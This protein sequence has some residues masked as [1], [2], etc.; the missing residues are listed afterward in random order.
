MKKIILLVFISLL[1][2]GCKEKVFE[3]KNQ[4]FVKL[5]ESNVPVY[6]DT[7]LKDIV[8]LSTNDNIELV[9]DNYKIDTDTL[10]EKEYEVFYKKDGKKFI[11]KFKVNILDTEAPIV[12]GGTNKTVFVGEEKELCDLITYGD[13]HDGEVSCKITGDYDLNTKGTYKLIYELSDKSNNI[14]KVNVT[15]NVVEKKI[16]SGGNTTTVEPKRTLFSDVIN[17]HKKDN[18]EIGIDVSKWQQVID[19]EQVKNAGA[20]FVLMRIGVQKT[21]KGELE[22]DPYY[23]ENMKNAKKAGLKVGVYL[24]SIATS[25]N[26]A[27]EHAKWV[28]KTL[29]GE[30][31]DLPVVFDW[32]NW[33]KW[34]S[35]KISFHEINE[36]ADTFMNTIKKSGYEAMLYSSK[37]YLES[38]W[39]NKLDYPVWLAHYTNKTNYEGDYVIWQLCNDGKIDGINGAVDIDVM[40][41]K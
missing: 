26:E 10:G 37:Y 2:V 8:E 16:N 13:N 33:S 20:T 30:K 34:N 18:T 6:S 11:Y 41:K 3:D 5:I 35:Y 32:E 14:K 9:S 21:A 28:L 25:K 17:A 38:I 39:A 36:V 24:Y 1:L 31:L 27:K 29:D 19:F 22:I 15:L 7:F 23:V 4:K 12:F 40:Y